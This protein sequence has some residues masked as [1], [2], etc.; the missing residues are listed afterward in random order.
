MP[1]N[2]TDV[3]II[4]EHFLSRNKFI[5]NNAYLEGGAFKWTARLPMKINNT[6]INNSAKYGQ[7]E[8]SVPMDI[9]LKVYRNEDSNISL[10]ELKPIY[11]SYNSA[12]R[13][14]LN[15]LLSGENVNYT[16]QFEIVDYYKQTITTLDG[17][18]IFI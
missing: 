13:L 16:F 12:E 18:Y 4:R 8:A 14:R 5:N 11:S 17:G 2:L 10:G 6:F 1:L 3:T 9:M 7:D 15:D